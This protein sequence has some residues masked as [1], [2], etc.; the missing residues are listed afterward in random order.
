MNP[1]TTDYNEKVLLRKD[2]CYAITINPD[3][4]HQYNVAPVK[5]QSKSKERLSVF[6]HRWQTAMTEMFSMHETNWYLNVEC[7]ENFE[8]TPR[9]HFHGWIKFNTNYAIREFLLI[10]FRALK[11]M[12]NIKIDQL[13]DP[14]KWELYCNKQSFL[15]LGHIDNMPPHIEDKT[16]WLK[17]KQDP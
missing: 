15:K 3:D 16:K 14:I 13:N 17:I 12:S 8:T 1:T 7:S 6:K 4:K 2:I 9:L 11:T 5:N 10:N